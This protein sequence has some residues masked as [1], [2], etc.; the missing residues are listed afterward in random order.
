[1]VYKKIDK[2][3]A[4][5]DELNEVERGVIAAYEETWRDIDTLEAI[6]RADCTDYEWHR[7]RRTLAK[8]RSQLKRLP[9]PEDMSAVRAG[10]LSRVMHRL[11]S[12]SSEPGRSCASPSARSTWS[13]VRAASKP[14][15]WSVSTLTRRSLGSRSAT[16]I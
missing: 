7:L 10:I 2:A 5:L 15:I 1:M 8:A 13:A 9:T 3:K 16:S 12:L 11:R 4:D 14:R 6:K